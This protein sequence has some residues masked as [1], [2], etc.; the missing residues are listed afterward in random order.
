MKVAVLYGGVSSERE[1]SILSGKECHNAL[2]NCGY[3]AYLVDIDTTNEA[4]ILKKIGDDVDICFNALH[5]Q[6]GED[7]KIQSILE[8]NNIKFTHSNADVSK[9]CME[10]IDT[11]DFLIKND[12]NMNFAKN[13][14]FD[15]EFTFDDV[16]LSTPYIIK[17]SNDGSSIGI[18]IVRKREEFPDLSSLCSKNIMAEE[19][20]PGRELTVAILN[21]NA[22]SVTELDIDNEFYDFE[23]KY[24]KGSESHICPADIDQKDFDY[25]LTISEKIYKLLGCQ[26]IARCDYRYNVDEE[27]FYFL[28]INTQPGMTKLSLAPEQAMKSGV[29]MEELVKRLVNDRL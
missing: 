6:F 14:F 23:E 22:L 17:P 3:D 7:G 13:Q 12:V 16:K 9:L 24:K 20:I 1:I 29:S 18:Y 25:L 4:D 27:K 15:T 26:G 5:G 11:I 21:G 28:E 10:K 8:K 19:F 2:V